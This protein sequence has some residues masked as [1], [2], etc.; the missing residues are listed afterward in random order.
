MI[1]FSQGGAAKIKSNQFSEFGSRTDSLHQENEILKLLE[2][3]Y[4]AFKNVRLFICGLICRHD[5]PITKECL[6]LFQG[7]LFC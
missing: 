2:S 6:S 4:G 7:Q 5:N 3:M 1:T